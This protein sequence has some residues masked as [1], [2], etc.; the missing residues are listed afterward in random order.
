MKQIHGVEVNFDLLDVIEQFSNSNGKL[1]QRDSFQFHHTTP[2]K[3]LRQ[4]EEELEII[5]NQYAR[6]WK[7]SDTGWFSL[8][9]YRDCEKRLSREGLMIQN[10]Q[11][12][13]MDDT[14]LESVIATFG[15]VF[16]QT[17]IWKLGYGEWM[18]IGTSTPREW[19]LDLLKERI[20]TEEVQSILKSQDLDV[21]PMLLTSQISGFDEGFH[22]VPDESLMHSETYPALRMLGNNA[23]TAPTPLTLFE[24]NNRHFSIQ[25]SLMIGGFAQTQSWTV[26]QLRAFSILQ[27]DHQFYDPKVFRSVVKRWLNLSPDETPLQ[28]LSASTAKNE[29]PWTY[30]SETIDH[31]NSL[32]FSRHGT[33]S[34]VG[35]TGGISLVAS[36]SGSTN[37]HLSPRYIISRSH[38][39]SYDSKRPP[40]PTRV[41]HEPR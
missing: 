16:N 3:F 24:K 25:S 7:A 21:W 34:G 5:I 35:Q 39:G 9:F 19:S 31:V 6:P 37:V 4:S 30:E 17:S 12:N 11:A 8:E 18:L 14:T 22:L 10:L 1:L 26:E 27:I 40:K 28:I 2:S 38:A 29:S 23:Y 36:L 33:T 20:E 32:V 13:H 41:S 15:S